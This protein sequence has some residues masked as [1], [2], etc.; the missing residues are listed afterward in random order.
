MK[1]Y[2]IIVAGG[3]GSRMKSTIPKQFL[4]LDGVPVV[5]RSIKTFK[6]QDNNI[7]IILVLPSEQIEHWEEMCKSY[8]FKIHHSIAI[9][10]VTR[11]DSVKSGLTLIKENDCLIA[12]HDAVRPLV[13][14]D[15]IERAF[16]LAETAGTALPYTTINDSLRIKTSDSSIP[17]KRENIYII[18][19][20]Q[21]FQSNLLKQAYTQDY[22]ENFTDDATVVENYGKVIHL[23]EGNTENIKITT[24]TDLL[25]AECLLKKKA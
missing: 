19:T 11:F 3:T 2:V 24:P 20:P 4:C 14:K 17:L 1:K 6:E 21:C 18:Q 15:T 7:S 16:A 5:M 22:N 12:I 13:S 23:F 25:I 9:G 8:N 10:G